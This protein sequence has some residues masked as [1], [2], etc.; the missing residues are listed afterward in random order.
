MSL[1][2]RTASGILP[3]GV[4]KFRVYTSKHSTS[5]P[6]NSAETRVFSYK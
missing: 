5:Q 1:V 4:S 3:N 6:L 2:L